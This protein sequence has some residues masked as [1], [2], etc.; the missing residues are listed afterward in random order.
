MGD[1]ESDPCANKTPRGQWYST[2]ITQYRPLCRPCHG[3]LDRTGR[4]APY[5]EAVKSSSYAACREA[6][7]A[8][9]LTT[10]EYARTFGTS[11]W[12]AWRILD[13]LASGCS[14]ESIIEAGEVLRRSA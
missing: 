8:L 4:R 11:A 12:R 6:A 2:D 1:G 7:G 3:Q 5:K 13:L 10:E 9:G 14:V